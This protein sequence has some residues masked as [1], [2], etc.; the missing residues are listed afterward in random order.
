M[1][2]GVGSLVVCVDDSPNPDGSGLVL[3]HIYTVRGVVPC[4]KCGSGPGIRL[5]EVRLPLQ[6]VYCEVCGDEQD[7]YEIVFRLDRFRPVNPDEIDIFRQIE[8]GIKEPA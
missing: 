8:A 6:D 5:M 3:G 2:I 7:N 1:D 4:R